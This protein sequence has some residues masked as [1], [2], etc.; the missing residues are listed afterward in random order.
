MKGIE[1]L[2][3]IV[4]VLFF[5]V[6]FFFYWDRTSAARRTHKCTAASIDGDDSRFYDPTILSLIHDDLEFL[7]FESDA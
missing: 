1:Y 7:S 3:I 4:V 5:S 6:R 2:H